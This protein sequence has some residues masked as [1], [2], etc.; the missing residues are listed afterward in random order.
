MFSSFVVIVI[1]IVLSVVDVILAADV[2]KFT[3]IK[4]DFDDSEIYHV[5]IDLS[6]NGYGGSGPNTTMFTLFPTED[7]GDGITVETSPKNLVQSSRIM[8]LLDCTT[9]TI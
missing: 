9:Q 4:L 7:D 3:P 6:R 5:V 2:A 1:V 8:G